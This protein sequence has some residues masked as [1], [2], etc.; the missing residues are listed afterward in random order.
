[1]ACRDGH[2]EA[3]S[4]LMQR[5]SA[6]F[7]MRPA[8]MGNLVLHQVNTWLGSSPEGAPWFMTT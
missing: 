7:P 1:M 4:S 5:L 3:C 2:P 6:E 8:L